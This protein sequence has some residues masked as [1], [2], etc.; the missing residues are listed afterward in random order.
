MK[1][2]LIG[3]DL[4]V[5]KDWRQEKGM[6]ENEMVKSHHWLNG[7]EFEHALGTGA[8]QESLACVHGVAK[9]QT[10]LWL[11]W[12]CMML[13]VSL[14]FLK[15]FHSL[16]FLY[17]PWSLR[18]AVFFFFFFNKCIYFNWRL[19]TLQYCIGFLT[20]PCSSLELGIQMGIL[21]YTNIKL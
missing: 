21:S 6:T 7:H 11:N 14:I 10:R 13:Q 17:L 5:G 9:S 1:N 15:P 8:G 16:A 19:I 4:D 18:K 3:R 2:W 20:S 12:T